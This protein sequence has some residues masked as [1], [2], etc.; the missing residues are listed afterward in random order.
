MKLFGSLVT[1]SRRN[2]K[3]P[4]LVLEKKVNIANSDKAVS[5]M[6]QTE[7]SL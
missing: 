5:G 3:Y 7:R 4:I 6:A 2:I 1:I